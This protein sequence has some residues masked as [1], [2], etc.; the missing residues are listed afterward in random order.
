[1]KQRAVAKNYNDLSY[2]G[3]AYKSGQS[4]WRAIRRY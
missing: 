3:D 4:A 1:L 2:G